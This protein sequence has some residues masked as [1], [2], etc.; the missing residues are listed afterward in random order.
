MSDAARALE[1]RLRKALETAR[2]ARRVEERKLHAIRDGAEAPLPGLSVQELMSL[3][4]DEIIAWRA[5]AAEYD[6]LG[7]PEDARRLQ[8]QVALV[9]SYLAE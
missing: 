4:E 2:G 7:Y 5:A 6:R 3:L 9:M 8:E 1:T